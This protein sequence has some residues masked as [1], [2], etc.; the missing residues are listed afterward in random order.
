MHPC[1]VN[2]RGGAE[3]LWCADVLG[4]DVP[5]DLGGALHRG[6]PAAGADPHAAHGARGAGAGAGDGAGAA[7]QRRALLGVRAGRR[8][9]R[10]LPQGAARRPALPGALLHRHVPGLQRPPA[11][12]RHRAPQLPPGAPDRPRRQGHPLA[13]APG[14]PH[15]QVQPVIL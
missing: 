13:S 8:P 12:P 6:V 11:L 3:P 15:H 9:A 1:L 2:F 5:G 4:V 14:V 7:L 10:R